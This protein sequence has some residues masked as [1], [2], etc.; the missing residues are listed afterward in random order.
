[1]KN[2][3]LLSIFVVLCGC[4]PTQQQISKEV[5]SNGPLNA[6]QPI[7]QTDPG[8]EAVNHTKVA[9][10]PQNIRPNDATIDLYINKRVRFI[11]QRRRQGRLYTVNPG[12][13]VRKINFKGNI[14]STAI[15]SELTSGYLLSY[16]YYDNGGVS[17]NGK[18][19]SSRYENRIDDRMLFYTH[20]TGKSIT[21]YIIGHAICEGYISSIDE[22]ID[23]P[24]MNDTVYDRQ[25]LIDLLNMRAGDKHTIDSKNSHYVMGSSLHHRDMGLDTIAE[26]LRGTE[27]KG[28]SLFYNNFL[29]DVLAN[30]TVF[31]SGANYDRLM[32]KVLQEKVKIA[33]PVSYE[34][35]Q[36]TLTNG[37]KS[38]F[39]GS[40]QTLASYS[41]FM[42]RLDFLRVALAMMEDYQQETCVGRYLKEIQK[43]AEPWYLDRYRSENARLWINNFAKKYGG[44]FYFSFRGMDRRNIFGTEGYNGQNMLID[45]DNSRIVITNSAATA[46]DTKKLM[47]DVIQKG[48]L[49]D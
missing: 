36:K 7:P 23:W 20:S 17:Y 38:P 30:Y 42:T 1:M 19:P 35:H 41:Y 39:Y 4:Q 49:P 43:R 9:E 28:R 44:Q 47:L 45:M 25:P 32:K 21:S 18:P 40:K 48:K 29:A 13:E 8:G 22:K 11:E 34:K 46:W 10:L 14:D 16:I 27:K 12:K 26:L 24:L 37:D 2:F 3:L 5:V 31:K 6:Y 15:S 33:H